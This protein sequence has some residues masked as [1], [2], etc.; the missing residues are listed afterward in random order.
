[1]AMEPAPFLYECA[2]FK[3]FTVWHVVYRLFLGMYFSLCTLSPGLD[4][5]LDASLDTS[6]DGLDA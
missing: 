2:E 3:F 5:S 6:L 4:A 1:M